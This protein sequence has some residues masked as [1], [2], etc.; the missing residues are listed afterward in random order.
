MD[1][2]EAAFVNAFI[3]REKRRRYLD[4]L[5]G[6]KRRK[7][8]RRIN[9]VLDVDYRYATVVPSHQRFAAPLLGL[10]RQRGAGLNCHVMADGSDFDG[11]SMRLEDALEELS[12]E[13]DDGVVLDCIPGH[14]ALYKRE[15]SG[16]CFIL[17]RPSDDG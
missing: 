2:P 15:G 9:H 7:I 14:L 6:P 5:A 4:L 3:V 1:E 16:G 17:E 13:F 12:G 10:L 11:T 8:L